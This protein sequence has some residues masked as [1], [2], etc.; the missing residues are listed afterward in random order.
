[1][2]KL[3]TFLLALI[4]VFAMAM[5]VCATEVTQEGLK[6]SLT[7]DKDTYDSGETITAVLTVTNVTDEPVRDLELKALIPA[8]YT[9]K[10]SSLSAATLDAGQSLTLTVVYTAQSEE[11]PETGDAALI[12]LAL[13][14]V[15]AAAALV[16]GGKSM[17]KRLLCLGL[18]LSMVVGMTGLGANAQVLEL[19]KKSLTVTTPVSVD[20]E[21]VALQAVVYYLPAAA[22]VDTDGDGIVDYMEQLV[23]TD[24]TL[25]D[26]DGDGLSDYIEYVKTNTNPLVVDTDGN[27]TPDGREDADGDGLTNLEELAWG[28]ALNKQDTDGDGLTDGQERSTGTNL[29]SDDTDGDGVTDGREVELGTDPGTYESSFEVTQQQGTASVE[30]ELEGQQVETLTIKPV[31]SQTLFP[32]SIPGYLGQAYDFQVEGQF[33]T[34]DI[35]FRFDPEIL[36][37]GAEPVIYYF[38]ERTQTLEQLDTVIGDGVATATVEHFSTYILLDR[39]TYD[40]SFTWDDVW[41]STG[42]YST[43]EVVLVVDDSGSMGPWGDNNDPDYERLTV[44]RNMIDKLP[45]GCKI[46]IVWFATKNKLLTTELTTDREA[47]K[48]LLT[49]EYF[50]S[51]GSYTNMY[52]ALNEAMTLFQS[53]EPD[54]L[55][56]AIVIT[57]GRAH[58]YDEL[59]ESTIAAAK[60]NNVRLYTVG[61]GGDLI[62]TDYLQP[63]AEQT[64]GTYHLAENADQLAAIYNQIGKMIDLSADTDGDGIPDYYEDNMVAFNGINLNL[65]KTKADTD[66]DGRLDGEEVNIKLV[67]SEDRSKVYI[68]GT[69]L[70]SPTLKDSDYDGYWDDVDAHPYDNSFTG[71]LTTGFATSSIDCNMNYSWFLED[72]SVYNADLSK[73]SVLFAAE[74][75]AGH[76]LA[77]TDPSG[78]F[79]TTGTSIAAVMDYFGMNNPVSVSLSDLY[80]DNHLSEVALGYHNVAVGNEL[81]TVIAVTIRGTN[82]T[83][84]EWSSNCDIGDISTDTAD[85]DWTNPLNHKG[86]D[87]AATRIR[88]VLESYIDENNLDR[89]GIV[90]WVTGHSRGA[91]IANIVGA[92]LEKEGKTAFTYTFAAPN[93]TLDTE[94][95]SYRSIF[96]VINEDDF[97]PCLPMEYW[98]YTTYGRA[99]TTASIKDGEGLEKE[100]ENLTGIGDYNPDSSGMEDCVRDI[101]LILPEGSDPRVES[102]RYTCACHGDGSDDTITIKN[103]GM[104]QENRE[105]AIAKIPQCALPY[106]IITRI[107]G[108]WVGG[109]DFYCCQLPAYLMQLLAAFM[110][111]D[112]DAY[113]FAVEL[114]IAKRYESA[115][116]AIISAG[117]SGIEHPHYTECYYV[118]TNH[119]TGDDFS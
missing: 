50:T 57:D 75:Y 14:L 78:S 104:S 67:Y 109:W 6:V 31:D 119:V 60:E 19:E 74:I 116:G 82:S 25:E 81:R 95:N 40:G 112:I 10:D 80:A 33:E 85:D 48:A 12:V 5:P 1:M 105:K 72:N 91:A 11:I 22:Y 18:C 70:S 49:E 21:T 92:N 51:S 118:L 42:T 113:R 114:N 73:L 68:K 53:D 2:K 65:D 24:P 17:A 23:G 108:G 83:I 102:F 39:T 45:D 76:T 7:A 54:A 99:T 89:D 43:V 34:A 98:G 55:K 35:S 28:T 41:D 90:Y 37:A 56:T 30:M 66:G 77:L 13:M 86:F 117:I 62:I 20:G 63:L 100:W 111:G 96:N 106:C 52:G 4:V 94:A 61:L 15:G 3:V 29:L 46:G 38:N 69:M 9:A 110:G 107:D 88:R 115:K 93:C 87:I 36:S 97:V 64:G 71:T 79:T 101:G 27:G 47:A 58:D 8:G 16:F 59:H 44:A 26:T 84:E 103:G 32:E